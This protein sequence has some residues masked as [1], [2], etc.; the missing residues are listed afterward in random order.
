MHRRNATAVAA[1]APQLENEAQLWGLSREKQNINTSLIFVA[2][3]AFLAHLAD[4]LLR[5]DLA[6]FNMIVD[7][8]ALTATLIYRYSPTLSSDQRSYLLISTALLLSTSFSVDL[9]SSF[10]A[11]PGQRH[12]SPQ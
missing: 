11:P 2:L 5:K 1:P 6:T 4:W 7:A 3:A 12:P 9:L 8:L 10:V